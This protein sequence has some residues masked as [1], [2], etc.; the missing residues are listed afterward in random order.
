MSPLMVI[1]VIVTK[2]AE[3]GVSGSIV[4]VVFLNCYRHWNVF[5]DGNVLLNVDLRI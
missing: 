5:L 3:A 2:T 1:I 4:W